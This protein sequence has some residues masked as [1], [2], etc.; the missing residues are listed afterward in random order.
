MNSST[1]GPP[2]PAGREPVTVVI[3][4][5]VDPGREDDYRAGMARLIKA[6]EGA[7]NNLGTVVLAPSPSEP[8][9]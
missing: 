3:T 4:R 8:N 2:S 9:V 1:C 6:A 5:T 7:P